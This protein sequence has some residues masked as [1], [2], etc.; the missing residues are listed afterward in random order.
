MERGAPDEPF[1]RRF[2]YLL[3]VAHRR[4]QAWMT[5]QYGEVTSAQ[6]GVLFSLDAPEGVLVGDVARSLGIGA[7]AA[8]GLVDR[9]EAI[10]L[11]ERRADPKDGRAARL[12]LTDKGREMRA[13]AAARTKEI[14]ARLVEDFSEHE[15]DI[16]ARWLMTVAERFSK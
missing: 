9:M 8:T 7:P 6:A 10:G 5:E 11:V 16:V 1:T 13:Y 12:F 14:N 15:L 3:S 4:L 2:I